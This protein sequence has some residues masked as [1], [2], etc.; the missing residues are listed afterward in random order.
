MDPTSITA[1]R[2]W[3]ELLSKKELDALARSVATLKDKPLTYH[4]IWWSLVE[5]HGA[6]VGPMHYAPLWIA[7]EKL[8]RYVE[9]K[10]LKFNEYALTDY[11]NRIWPVPR[12]NDRGPN[13]HG[14][15]FLERLY[16]VLKNAE[17]Q[18]DCS[19]IQ[20]KILDSLDQID[21]QANGFHYASC[22]QA[23]PYYQSSLRLHQF[24]PICAGPLNEQLQTYNT[25]DSL[26]IL[27][28]C[29]DPIPYILRLVAQKGKV[30][31]CHFP[32][33]QQILNSLATAMVEQTV[34]GY[35]KGL[36]LRLFTL[37]HLIGADSQLAPKEDEDT[38]HNYITAAKTLAAKYSTSLLE[39]VNNF[40]PLA[41]FPE[42]V[43]RMQWIKLP[44]WMEL[45]HRLEN[46]DRRAVHV[47]NALLRDN[48]IT[49]MNACAR[50]IT[51]HNNLNQAQSFI[52]YLLTKHR[53]SFQTVGLVKLIS[54]CPYLWKDDAAEIAD[55]MVSSKWF[56]ATDNTA[57]HQ[58]IKQI[59]SIVLTGRLPS[60]TQVS[61]ALN[62]IGNHDE[63][64]DPDGITSAALRR[65]TVMNWEEQGIQFKIQDAV[66]R[67]ITD[68]EKKIT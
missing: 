29:Q 27:Q 58:F 26:A 14:S 7:F 16:D 62:E 45:V 36:I 10:E 63:A 55:M 33:F 24:T 50:L 60:L 6:A 54:C 32:Q 12:N 5:A 46:T 61:Q 57:V 17:S 56:V 22:Y 39:S 11:I 9:A 3:S 51:Y 35:K 47:L 23:Y 8:M 13:F 48:Y 43:L 64:K 20:Q 31:G 15:V 59:D 66:Y 53:W 41:F 30:K 40:L 25:P 44:D 68:D 19:D 67:V 42:K 4:Q 21:W 37:C 34:D 49:L 65:K 1:F 18:L 2:N 52:N 28:Q 38:L